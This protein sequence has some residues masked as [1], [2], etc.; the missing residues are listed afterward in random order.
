[1]LVYGAPRA[2]GGIGWL[3]GPLVV[4]KQLQPSAMHRPTCHSWRLAEA[5]QDNPMARDRQGQLR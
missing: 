1:M 4:A 5:F 3:D 2:M